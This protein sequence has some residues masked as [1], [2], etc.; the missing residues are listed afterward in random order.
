MET[1]FQTSFIPK[2]PLVPAGIGSKLPRQKTG[3]SFFMIA[4]VL[5]FVVS[6]GAAGG[7]YAWKQ[8]LTSS[9]ENYKVQLADRQKQ[10]NIDLIEQLKQE[11]V[12]I[13]LASKI[14]KNHLAI[15][16]I[17]AII[18]RMTSENVRFT[19]LDLSNDPASNS[20]GLK[21]S[22][23]GYGTS[24]SAVAFQSD[25]LGQLEQYGLRKVVKNPILSNPALDSTGSVSFGF[26]ATIDPA[27]LSYESSVSGAQSSSDANSSST[28]SFNKTQ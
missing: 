28:D 23:N 10:F 26:T 16:Q 4:G 17:F 5:A 13:D 7:A 14:M 19:S 22:L 6:L 3:T 25:V 15:S 1:K 24:F 9:Q 20:N 12:K 21:I 18:G 8:L 27:T 2:K 11:N